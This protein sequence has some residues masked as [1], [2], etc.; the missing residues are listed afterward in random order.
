MD[1][2][3]ILS[4]QAC[5]LTK[6]IT[7]VGSSYEISPY[8]NAKHFTVNEK[9]FNNFKEYITILSQLTKDPHSF[10]IR[11]KL[12]PEAV[13]QDGVVT[14]T[15]DSFEE[16]SRKWIM[17]DVDSHPINS[18]EPFA[19]T[20]QK[21]LPKPLQEV[22]FYWSFSSKHMIHNKNTFSVHLWFLLD[23][24]LNEQ[25]LRRIFKDT[26]FDTSVFRTVQPHY[27]AFPI[28]KECE[29]PIKNRDG[30]F[31]GKRHIAIVPDSWLKTPS[32]KPLVRSQLPIQELDPVLEQELK[33]YLK[34]A[35]GKERHYEV[36]VFVVNAYL[37]GMDETD[38][39]VFA[40]TFIQDHGR[41]PQP[42]E[43][44]NWIEWAKKKHDRGEL[45]PTLPRLK[46]KQAINDFNDESKE[47]DVMIA[48]ESTLDIYQNGQYKPT[49]KNLTKIFGLDDT[50]QG[51]LVDNIFVYNTCFQKAPPWDTGR[52]VGTAW[53][54]DD[55]LR[56]AKWLSEKYQINAPVNTIHEAVRTVALY[57]PYHPVREYLNSLT[58]DKKERIHNF[59]LGDVVVTE[60]EDDQDDRYLKN[61]AEKFFISAVARVFKPGCKMDNMIVLEGEQGIGKSPLC[62]ILGGEWFSDDFGTSNIK[63][64]DAVISLMGKWIIEL[65]EMYAHRKADTDHYKSFLSRQI[66]R[67]RP[68]YG[69]VIQDF[70]R[71][72][73][74]IGSTNRYEYLF[75]ETGGKRFW[76]VHCKQINLKRLSKIRDQLW[77][78]ALYMYKQGKTWHFEDESML[79]ML[80]SRASERFIRDEWETDVVNWL[81]ELEDSAV[82]TGRDI[83]TQCFGY[84]IKDFSRREQGRVSN[85]LRRLGYRRQTIR[86]DGKVTKGYKKLLT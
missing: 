34:N 44:E 61:I 71:Q 67:V 12:K 68:H 39:I 49:R 42:N 78:E 79:K 62:A 8:D 21:L 14:R 17:L 75:D 3:T 72:C 38:I 15:K 22:S 64:K 20:V 85:I 1:S 60:K 23:K 7:K 50:M 2:F 52:K 27:T 80:G 35:S 43:I 5:T 54:D 16:V 41:N 56:A 24:A 82:F 63:D 48:W 53:T 59:F 73:V 40:T 70:P 31:K 19:I 86:L 51:V 57:N 81:T 4:N 66:D 6:T 58:W 83:W 84:E 9:T 33:D 55:A 25:Q 10:I 77:A 37:S 74:L 32:A 18:R 45:T 76:P 65:P 28:I 26:V 13:N 36:G 11:G 69:R 46:S 47:S 30:A 29:Q